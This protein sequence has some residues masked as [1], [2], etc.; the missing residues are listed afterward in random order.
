VAASQSG[1][2]KNGGEWRFDLEILKALME[3]FQCNAFL[4]TFFKHYFPEFAD[5]KGR[6]RSVI[7]SPFRPSL[8]L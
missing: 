7:I 8:A 6:L 3:K 1:L 4:T 2:D 5:K